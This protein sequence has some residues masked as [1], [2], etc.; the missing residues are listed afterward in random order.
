MALELGLEERFAEYGRR[1]GESAARY[2]R[3]DQEAL[4]ETN[5]VHLE[6]APDC[7]CPISLDS[8]SEA[9]ATVDGSVYD[10]ACIEQWILQKQQKGE[11][12]TSPTT[13]VELSST[14]LFPLVTIQRAVE[15]LMNTQGF[16]RLTESEALR[17]KLAATAAQLVEAAKAA[18]NAKQRLAEHEAALTQMAEQLK[19]CELRLQSAESDCRQL[20]DTLNLRGVQLRRA[21]RWSAALQEHIDDEFVGT[22]KQTVQTSTHEVIDVE[23]LESTTPNLGKRK[24]FADGLEGTGAQLK[25]ETRA[26]ASRVCC[27][28]ATRQTHRRRMPSAACVLQ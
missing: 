9:V 10:R 3:I 24:L 27:T 4:R 12:I 8:I 16:Q 15:V 11:P 2:F 22:A 20:Q 21:R 28:D 7:I 25:Q 17:T 14:A 18:D 5:R 13:G 26:V 23:L 1:W 19:D 6:P